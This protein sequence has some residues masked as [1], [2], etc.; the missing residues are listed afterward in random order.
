IV[1]LAR[2]HRPH[3][4]LPAQEGHHT[5]PV[6]IGDPFGPSRRQGSP[7]S[8]GKAVGKAS[9]AGHAVHRCGRK[10]GR[11]LG[12]GCGE[13]VQKVGHGAPLLHRRANI[14]Q[15][16]PPQRCPRAGRGL[17]LDPGDGRLRGIQPLGRRFGHPG[18]LS[19]LRGHRLA[20]ARQRRL[21]RRQRLG[22]RC[23]LVAL[24]GQRR[25]QSGDVLRPGRHRLGR[26]RAVAC[27]RPLE[28]RHPRFKRGQPVGE[29]RKPVAQR[30]NL[31]LQRPTVR[32]GGQ[33]GHGRG[34]FFD[35]PGLSGQRCRR[36]A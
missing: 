30:R 20:Q 26:P 7:G 2:R 16:R 19:L 34:Q 6:A 11:H 9:H 1:T 33:R 15:H 32:R 17:F 10:V 27:G 14:G 23:G 21:T 13:F 12:P 29:R 24:F 8:L 35:P 4:K 22:Q 5:G 18:H 25:L 28:R 31:G 36:L 3:I